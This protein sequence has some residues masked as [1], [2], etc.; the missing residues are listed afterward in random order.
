MTIQHFLLTFA[1]TH[2]PQLYRTTLLREGA[3]APRL[4][5]RGKTPG[6]FRDAGTFQWTPAVRAMCEL[7]VGSIVELNTTGKTYVLSGLAHSGAASLDYAISKQTNWLGDIFGNTA[8]GQPLS[9][10]VFLRTNPNR[11]QPGPVVIALNTNIIP[12]NN[13]RVMVDEREVA[14]IDQLQSLL[15]GLQPIKARRPFMRAKLRA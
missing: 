2:T 7:L 5:V 11:K 10:R 4:C 3:N 8:S 12:L 6:A 9:P 15:E 14:S 1:L 13:I